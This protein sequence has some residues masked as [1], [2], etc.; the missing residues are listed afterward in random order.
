MKSNSWRFVEVSAGTWRWQRGD[1]EHAVSSKDT[2]PDLATCILD[3]E[4]N[5]FDSARRERR[6]RPRSQPGREMRC[7]GGA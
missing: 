1:S 3:A 4:A 2:F 5:G 6:R 7:V